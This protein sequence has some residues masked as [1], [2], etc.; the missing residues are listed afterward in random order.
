MEGIV[1]IAARQVELGAAALE[2]RHQIGRPHLERQLVERAV[3][4]EQDRG[5]QRHRQDRHEPGDLAHHVVRQPADDLEPLFLVEAAQVAADRPGMVG[6][7]AARRDQAAEIDAGIA[8]AEPVAAQHQ[9]ELAE[10]EGERGACR[11]QGTA[12]R[13]IAV[14]RTQER[15]SSS[16]VVVQRHRY[17][18][19]CRVPQGQ[20]INSSRTGQAWAAQPAVARPPSGYIAW[21]T[22]ASVAIWT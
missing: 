14:E 21:A 12:S 19:R 1:A 8:E 3:G 10:P 17:E 11:E 18:G 22:P 7:P 16:A 6:Q 15:A 2:M 4:F 20:T 9:A 5:E 13:R